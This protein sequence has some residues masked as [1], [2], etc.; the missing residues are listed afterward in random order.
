MDHIA[1]LNRIGVAALVSKVSK[2]WEFPCPV[3]EGQM[4]YI[5]AAQSGG[6]AQGCTYEAFVRMALEGA[7]AKVPL[8]PLD[9]YPKVIADEL[10]AMHEANGTP[11]AYYA[12]GA[13]PVIATAMGDAFQVRIKANWIERACFWVALMGVSGKGKDP[14]IEDLVAPLKEQEIKFHQGNKA[15]LESWEREDKRTRGS[16]PMSNEILVRDFTIEALIETLEANPRGVLVS[17]GELTG[18]VNSFGQYKGGGGN[19]RSIILSIFS[20]SM[21]K[22]KR[23]GKVPVVIPRPTVSVLGGLQPAL[24]NALEGS[25]GLRAR[26]MFAD[27]PRVQADSF[28]GRPDRGA[29]REAHPEWF[30][31]IERMISRRNL[32]SPLTVVLDD[33]ARA[34]CDPLLVAIDNDLGLGDGDIPEMYRKMKANL[35]RM[36][37]VCLQMHQ[38][39]TGEMDKDIDEEIMEKVIPLWKWCQDTAIDVLRSE[40]PMTVKDLEVKRKLDAMERSIENRKAKGLPVSLATLRRSGPTWCK[41]AHQRELIEALEI[42]GYDS[43]CQKRVLPDM[44]GI[45]L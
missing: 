8:P 4:A 38:T 45:D 3:H 6:C 7:Q 22:K 24:F 18:F 30:R 1:L 39:V 10:K 2:G 16:I 34:L 31:M 11:L 28:F 33:G 41:R 44:S 12:L 26:F 20:G 32:L 37:L 13:L 9:I 27:G 17:E 19:D 5:T 15:D 21:I 14:A 29:G 23:A 35:F 42:M 36:G 40:D 43:R 25:D